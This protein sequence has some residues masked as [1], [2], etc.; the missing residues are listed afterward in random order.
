MFSSF[1]TISLGYHESNKAKTM[2]SGAEKEFGDGVDA[3]Q[4]VFYFWFYF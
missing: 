1:T 2:T 3:C 4:Y